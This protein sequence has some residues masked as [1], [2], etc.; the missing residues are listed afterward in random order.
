MPATFGF[1]EDDE[2]AAAVDASRLD[3]ARRGG[4]IERME[5]R[6]KGTFWV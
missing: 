3:W 6:M 2:S 4:R 1:V 5:G